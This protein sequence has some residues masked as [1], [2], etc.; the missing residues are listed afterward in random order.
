M[1]NWS[2]DINTLKKYPQQYTIWRLEQLIN[3]GLGKEK[4]NKSEL[5][6]YFN[7]LNID[8]QKKEYL[9]LLLS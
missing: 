5:K 4:L 6:K 2:T 1:Y 3:F 8:P 9:R 7:K